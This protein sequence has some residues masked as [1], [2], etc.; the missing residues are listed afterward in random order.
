MNMDEDIRDEIL[1][2][3]PQKRNVFNFCQNNRKFVGLQDLSDCVHRSLLAVFLRL[4]GLP[5]NLVPHLE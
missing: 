5:S 3:V 1:N 2:H 4:S